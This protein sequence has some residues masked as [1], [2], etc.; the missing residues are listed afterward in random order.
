MIDRALRMPLHRKHEMIRGGALE[1]FDDS[2]LGRAGDH[3]Q[4]IADNVR[5]LVMAR[6]HRDDK[7]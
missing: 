1:R 6:I 2:V 4:S 5:G 7:F 3:A